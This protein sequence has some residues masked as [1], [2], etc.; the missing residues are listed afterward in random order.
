MVGEIASVDGGLIKLH[1]CLLNLGESSR[2]DQ[3]EVV[4][5]V[6]GVTIEDTEA[7]HLA[8]VHFCAR[9]IKLKAFDGANGD[10]A[11]AFRFLRGRK[12]SEEKTA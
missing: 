1:R 4:S 3:D 6:A 2:F 10:R 11:A 9:W 7:D 8:G 5:E 12:R